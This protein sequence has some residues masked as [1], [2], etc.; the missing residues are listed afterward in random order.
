M[1]RHWNKGI[2]T[3][4]IVMMLARAAAAQTPPPT[5][6]SVSEILANMAATTAGLTSYAVPVHIDARVRNGI[7][8]VPVH[9]DGERYFAAPARSALRMN[10][11]PSIAK[12][13]S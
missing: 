1:G 11:V 2:V 4:A 5:T 8:S 7:L 12:Q 10:S 9:M 3:A 13:F 6:V